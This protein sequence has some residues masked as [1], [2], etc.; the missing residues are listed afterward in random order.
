MSFLRKVA[1]RLV[2]APGYCLN[3]A[4][5]ICLFDSMFWHIL[6]GVKRELNV[7]MCVMCMCTCFGKWMV[8][9]RAYYRRSKDHFYMHYKSCVKPVNAECR[10]VEPSV[11]LWFC[12]NLGVKIWFVCRENLE[13]S[14]P[15]FGYFSYN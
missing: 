2:W 14:L 6:R 3:I 9:W 4:N 15:F 13:V 7:C 11:G 10:F 5:V 12:K 1:F 8:S